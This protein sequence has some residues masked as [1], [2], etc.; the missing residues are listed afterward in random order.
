MACMRAIAAEL[1]LS[2]ATVSRALRGH[3]SVKAETRDL[4]FQKAKDLGYELNGYLG[5]LM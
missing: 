5:E 2:V 4:I 1:D 3:P